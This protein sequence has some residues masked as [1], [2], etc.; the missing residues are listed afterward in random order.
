ML[1]VWVFVILILFIFWCLTPWW[2]LPLVFILAAVFI[3]LF[4]NER[5]Y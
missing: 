3:V 4:G 1:G 2:F 5:Y